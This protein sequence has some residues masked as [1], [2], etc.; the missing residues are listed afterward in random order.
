MSR[1][2]PRTVGPGL[3]PGAVRF[4]R[5][6]GRG[7]RG[8]GAGLAG[9]L[10]DSD[11]TV[12]ETAAAAL[13]HLGRH[14][15]AAT[16]ALIA[17]LG[18]GAVGVRAGR[19]DCVGAGLTR[20]PGCG[21]GARR[22]DGRCVRQGPLRGRRGLG[23]MGPAGAPALIKAI[24]D[25]DAAVRVHVIVALGQIGPARGITLPALLA[26]AN[27][28]SALIR[29]WAFGA[30]LGRIGTESDAVIPALIEGLDDDDPDVCRSAGYRLGAIRPPARVLP[31]LLGVLDRGSARARAEAAY[32]GA[33]SARRP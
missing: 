29:S 7:R 9:A 11:P 33:A 3:R 1:G 6:G 20:R 8:G 2:T 4:G 21:R 10:G 19:R 25:R 13:G 31:A 32:T 26:A 17:A 22:G 15:G 30:A 16:P 14:S 5:E 24:D 23:R 28:P 27:D 12:R 18:D